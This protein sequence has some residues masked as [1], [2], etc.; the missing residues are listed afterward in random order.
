VI[1]W[2]LV[3]ALTG[4][5][6]VYSPECR[7]VADYNAAVGAALM[8]LDFTLVPDTSAARLPDS[9]NLVYIGTPSGAYYRQHLRDILPLRFSGDTVFVADTMLV[10]EDFVLDCQFPQPGGPAVSATIGRDPRAAAA[11][12]NRG[13]HDF[14]LARQRDG[15]E[16][17]DATCLGRFRWQGKRLLAVD[18]TWQRQPARPLR[19]TAGDHVKLHCDSTQLTPDEQARLLRLLEVEYDGYTQLY[20]IE[21]PETV[22]VYG[23]ND[24]TLARTDAVYDV[25]FGIIWHKCL[26]PDA[27]AHPRT[28]L[29]LAH[30]LAHVAFQGLS[31]RNPLRRG[32]ED[33][34]DYAPLVGIMPF[35]RQ[36]LGDSAWPARLDSAARG[37]GFFTQLYRGAPHTYAALM[38]ETDRRFGKA[39]IGRAVNEV[40][41]TRWVRLGDMEQFMATLGRLSGDSDFARR[42]AA[43][44]PSPLSYRLR[45]DLGWQDFGFRPDLDAMS[46]AGRFVIESVAVGSPADSAGLHA[47]DAFVAI[48]GHNLAT[49]RDD[50]WRELVRKRPGEMLFVTVSGRSQRVTLPVRRAGQH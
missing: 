44:Y 20:G 6:I 3:C 48:D 46:L 38:E 30:E 39:V 4:N 36:V 40:L 15:T 19:L 27:V 42:V 32:C 45:G 23:Y 47:G 31:N 5:V 33:W 50:C 25:P 2:L 1:V 14:A 16:A 13:D 17:T 12:I 43:G 49:A 10:A 28:A 8:G 41:P 22:S 26:A 18:V 7:Q 24:T 37:R 35:V 21:M 9:G 34:G 29:S 11:G